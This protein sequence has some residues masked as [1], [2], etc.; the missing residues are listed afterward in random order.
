MTDAE[1]VIIARKVVAAYFGRRRGL[2]AVLDRRGYGREWFL[3]PAY[4]RARAC[5]SCPGRAARFGVAD[6]VRAVLGRTGVRAVGAGRTGWPGWAGLA[7]PP[8]RPSTLEV[9]AG[10]RPTRAGWPWRTRIAVYLWAVEGLSIREVA[11]AL[12]VSYA[13]ARRIL[14]GVYPGPLPRPAGIPP[15]AVLWRKREWWAKAKRPE[16]G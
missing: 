3:W 13:W 14:A 8:D 12:G 16:G 5:P 10:E 9:W 11:V 4:A 7:A 1:L 2:A 6:E 15:A